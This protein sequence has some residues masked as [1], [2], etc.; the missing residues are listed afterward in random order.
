MDITQ[1]K[2]EDLEVFQN[3]HH[4]NYTSL[5]TR[6]YSYGMLLDEDDYT[7]VLLPEFSDPNDFYRKQK[8]EVVFIPKACILEMK[9]LKPT[10]TFSQISEK[11]NV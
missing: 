10:K 1:T 6:F 9:E 7:I 4:G 5:L 3:Q 8:A 11:E 2:V